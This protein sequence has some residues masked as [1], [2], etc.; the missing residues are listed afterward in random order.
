MSNQT[1][2]ATASAEIP[3]SAASTGGPTVVIQAQR[4]LL[5]LDLAAIWQ[6]RELLYFLIWR[7][8]KVRYKQT[9]VGVGWAVLQPLLT[10]V[11][12]TLVF[13]GIAKISADGLPYPIFC[14]AGLLPWNYFSQAITQS[15]S[16]LVGSSNLITKIYFP[17][18]IVPLAAAVSPVVDFTVGFFILL[19]M[20]AWYGIVPGWEILALPL[21]LLAALATA[22]A[23]SLWLSAMMVKYRDVRYII[24]FMLQI[25]MYA[26]PIAYPISK[27]P[28]RWRLLY[29]LN[30][31]TGVSEGFR[32]A[33]LG[34]A[35][36]D[37]GPMAIS[38]AVVL[39]LLIGGT[40]YFRKMEETFADI[41]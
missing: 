3:F 26:S 14:F 7:D 22:L 24:P 35:A 11:V 8:V 6:Y 19:A 38:L 16:S 2:S 18:L 17:R 5:D 41:I 9:A 27:V 36:P 30:P 20:M 34:N 28:E 23:V 15:G 21:F 4:G 39:A 10:M 40:I 37:L 13:N 1:T 25:W 12:F 33:L 32:W 31:M 29:S